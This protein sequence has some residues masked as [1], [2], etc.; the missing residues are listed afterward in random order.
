[1]TEAS[2][3]P[4][5][6]AAR[7][8]GLLDNGLISQD[9]YD[10]LMISK[11]LVASTAQNTSSGTIAQDGSV[12]AGEKG[13][14]AGS[15]SPK[16]EQNIISGNNN[17][18]ANFIDLHWPKNEEERRKEEDEERHE[19]EKKNLRRQLASY[20]K[21]MLAEHGTI[22]LR[23]IKRDGQQVVSLDLETVYVPLAA[24]HGVNQH[25]HFELDRVLQQGQHLVITGGPGC[26]KTTVLQHIAYTLCLAIINNV[27]IL[28][29]NKLG[30]NLYRPID[31]QQFVYDEKISID[32]KLGQHKE[33]ITLPLP[34]YVPLSLYNRYYK[35]LPAGAHAKQKNLASFIN[36]YLIERQASFNLPESFF[37]S[38]LQHDHAVILLLDGLDEVP[39]EKERS[40][41][42]AAIEDLVKA[43]E[44]IRVVVTCRSA[45]YKE[46]TAIGRGFSQIQVLPLGQS[47]LNDMV[48]HGYSAI[49]IDNIQKAKNDAENL[50]R[51]I[52]KLEEQ[53][54]HRSGDEFKTL[55]DS[56]L[57]VRLL[58][59]VHYSERCLP[60]QRA[61]LYE[62]AVMNMLYPDYGMDNEVLEHIGRLI[63]GSEKKHRDLSQY[64]AFQ[65]HIK[66][67]KQGREISEDGL[68]E[69]LSK[70]TDYAE[71]CEDF[72]QLTRLRGTLMEERFGIYRFIH[73]AFQEF[74]VARYL[75]EVLR[76]EEKIAVF[77]Q[78]ERIADSWW[79]EVVLLTIGYLSIDSSSAASILIQQLA[80]IGEESAEKM[81]KLAPAI[82]VASAGLAWSALSDWPE[83]PTKLKEVIPKRFLEIFHNDTLFPNYTNR[84]VAG[85]LLGKLG[86]PR[87]HPDFWH[88]PDEELFG[89]IEISEGKFVFGGDK[90]ENT[91]LRQDI[92]LDTFYI[93]R[94]PVTVAQFRA[95]INDSKHLPS[96]AINLNSIA[97]HPVNLTN[98]YDV[99]AYI[100]WINQKIENSDALPNNIK[101]LLIDHGYK[102][103]LPSEAEWEKAARGRD[104]RLYPW[105]YEQPE[106]AYAN[107]YETK[108]G[109]TSPVGCFPDGE[110]P[111]GLLDC[112]GNVWEWTRN[113][114][115]ETDI[116]H[117]DS[118]S[119]SNK[120]K[121]GASG[122][123]VLR[124]GSFKDSSLYLACTCRGRSFPDY[125]FENRGFR[126]ALIKQELL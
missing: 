64:I 63:G 51:S 105:G 82:Q 73:L 23:G 106:T 27:P 121:N 9:E 47:H 60:E 28:A 45:A 38:L 17:L 86:D 120:M 74:L 1:M 87:F 67:D 62:V 39:G 12:A 109:T 6:E 123:H 126:L 32:D 70:N 33:K 122:F 21:W 94:Y 55:V 75:S 30:L 37:Q 35:E 52:D 19:Q 13:F 118:F 111:Y 66:G 18:V 42:R 93:N 50:L 2:R 40:R 26:G 110:S 107:F 71:L 102:F 97:N 46:R 49:H 41:V 99:I 8:Q 98:W 15:I 54:R 10:T 104:G 11:G 79:R 88:L 36:N 25:E 95:F 84:I 90:N 22:E 124:G 69:I 96:S 103:F 100:D 116:L 76:T 53:R 7:L 91:L 108:L 92:W 24:V 43:R 59:V 125:Q 119:I 5:E 57:M 68:R 65:M 72:I 85:N 101:S 4:E 78:D 114:A 48:R 29:K 44:K 80:G 81:N 3:S 14:A 61:E 31:E 16:A 34:I 115:D 89:F 112:A 20:L 77:F 113:L 117:P 58:L 83:A 56:P